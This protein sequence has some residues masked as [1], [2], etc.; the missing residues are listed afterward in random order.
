M[1]LFGSFFGRFAE[2]FR[3][4][5]AGEFGFVFA[6]IVKTNL[7]HTHDL[8]IFCARF[9]KYFFRLPSQYLCGCQLKNDTENTPLEKILIAQCARFENKCA[10]YAAQ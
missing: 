8:Q 10:H 2:L 1:L 4:T 7:T 5:E 9:E 3:S 6:H